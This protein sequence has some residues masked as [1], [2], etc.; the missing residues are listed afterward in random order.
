[1]LKKFLAGSLIFCM[2]F[3]TTDEVLA[4]FK[5]APPNPSTEF[6]IMDYPPIY[7]TYSWEVLPNTE[8][9]Q[10]QIFK[11][12]KLFRELKNSEA[13][14]KVTD[15]NPYTE[16]GKYFWQVRAVDKKNNPLSDWSEKSFFEITAPVNFAV[17]GDSISHGGANFIPSGQLACQ[18]E[19]FCNV[20]VKNLARSGDTTLQMIERFERDVLPFQP[21]ILIIMGGTNDIRNGYG[22]DY[23]IKNLETLREKCLANNITPVFCTI[24]PMNEKIIRSRNIFITDD[25]WRTERTK[26]NSWIIQGGGIEISRELV[27][28]AEELRED[29]TPDG[30][31]PNLRG[32]MLMGKAIEKYL[33]EN[34][35]ALITKKIWE[36]E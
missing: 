1:M 27:D 10:V 19:T 17:L 18:W 21:K 6:H 31:H 14:N 20:P 25:D 3:L 22:A 30:L 13:F 23:V 8:F 7:P 9:Y 26:L 15:L 2:M 12:G 33:H 5:I 35:P 29:L 11:D 32:K 28:F 34:F 16:S 36:I 4:K 24:P